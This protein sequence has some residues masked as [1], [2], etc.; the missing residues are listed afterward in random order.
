MMPGYEL[1]TRTRMPGKR[2]NAASGGPETIASPLLD[3]RVQYMG[4][5]LHVPFLQLIPP[6]RRSGRPSAPE[7][8]GFV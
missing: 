7:T 1:A 5:G 3:C 2:L 4:A 6:A 8:A